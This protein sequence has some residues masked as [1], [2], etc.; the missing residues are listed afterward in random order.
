MWTEIVKEM[1]DF[2]TAVLT[3]VDASGYPFSIRCK[4][5]PD[6]VAQVLRVQIPEYI[7]FKPGPAGLLYHKHDESLWNLKSLTLRGLLEQDAQGWFFRPL[8][9]TPGAGIGGL[10]AMVKFVKDG[11]RSARQY[12]E[13]RHLPRPVIAWDTVHEIWAEIHTKG[14]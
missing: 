8:K 11:R 3:S 1:A 9:Y 13:K 14:Q 7:Q 4:P 5:N 2:S 6:S 10:P 12:L